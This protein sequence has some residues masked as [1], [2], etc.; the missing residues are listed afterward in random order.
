MKKHFLILLFAGLMPFSDLFSQKISF[1][2]SNAVPFAYSK[3]G[4]VRGCAG[5]IN[6]NY[7]ILENDYGGAFDFKNNISTYVTC[8]SI[9]H[10]KMKFRLN[11][12]EILAESKKE[13]DKII[14]Y[15]VITWKDKI[16]A[17][18]TQK[19]ASAKYFQVF[20][21]IFDSNGKLIRPAIEL[22]TIQHKNASGSFLGQGGLF[23]NGRNTLSVVHD[24][25]YKITLDSSKLAMYSTP[26][27]KESNVKVLIYDT[28][29]NLVQTVVA[30]LPIETKTAHL[31]DFDLDNNGVLYF[32]TKAN[33]SKSAKKNEKDDDNT[34]QFH[35]INTKANNSL[36]TFPI[37]V[38]NKIINEA[39]LFL[40]NDNELFCFGT[41]HDADNKKSNGKTT[42]AFSAFLNTN[43]ANSFVTSQFDIPQPTRDAMEPYK[44]KPKNGLLQ[45]F[46]LQNAF[47]DHNG[48]M[49][50]VMKCEIIKVTVKGTTGALNSY[51]EQTFSN[52]YMYVSKDKKIKW[53]TGS[54]DFGKNAEMAT[55]IDRRMYYVRND[56]LSFVFLR[57]WV[58]EK[59]PM[60]LYEANFN[61][62][63]GNFDDN[64]K[65]IG[66]IP[67]SL[68]NVHTV[69]NTLY[70]LPGNEFIFTTV[71][72]RLAFLKYKIE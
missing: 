45:Q 57:N 26:E 71:G 65:F 42:G 30:A 9:S 52:L 66:P 54:N 18:Y 25:K 19:N 46:S 34:F 4:S 39:Q 67:S 22:G 32:L 35:Q 56:Q 8:F 27:D 31:Y 2:S 62:A 55:R 61:K 60:G 5:I 29:F 16:V 14:F 40:K 58:V 63:N 3:L 70:H 13:V 10:G 68:G 47:P 20:A 12:N 51:E 23:V 36:K 44:K 7:Y 64:L 6:D 24:F 53:L 43:G 28:D 49:Y 33:L 59:E 17:F 37:V 21:A 38:N 15:D 41:Y 50:V 48:G 11:L 72:A 1:V 69:D